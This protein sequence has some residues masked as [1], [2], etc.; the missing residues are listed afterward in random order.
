MSRML[1]GTRPLPSLDRFMLFGVVPLLLFLFLSCPV[2]PVAGICATAAVK[3]GDTDFRVLHESLPSSRPPP[4]PCRT[5]RS[6]V[7]VLRTLCERS[8]NA[9]G[10]RSFWVGGFAR[11]WG[12]YSLL[13]AGSWLCIFD[14]EQRPRRQTGKAGL[15][16][17][18]AVSRD[19]PTERTARRF[20]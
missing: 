4:P 8:D 11:L 12:S 20:D 16:A 1:I 18:V 2:L 6:T 5:S 17:V 9:P 7:E 3:G 13:R 15:C 14:G 19:Y 10:G